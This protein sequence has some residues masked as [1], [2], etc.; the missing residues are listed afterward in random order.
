MAGK[1]FTGALLLLGILGLIEHR[2]LLRSCVIYLLHRLGL[3]RTQS[4]PQNPPL[5]DEEEPKDEFARASGHARSSS[6]KAAANPSIEV[7]AQLHGLYKQGTKGDLEA[8]EPS[9]L[10][11]LEHTKWTVPHSAQMLGLILDGAGLES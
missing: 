5:E 8:P 3:I 11:L 1:L 7:Q 4:L 9:K 2:K 6:F 10:F